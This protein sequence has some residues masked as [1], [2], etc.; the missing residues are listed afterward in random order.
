VLTWQKILAQGFSSAKELLQF[1]QLPLELYS[2]Q[3]EQSF[4]TRIPLSF[5][6]R[7]QAGNPQDPL[8]LQVLAS[9]WE[10]QQHSQYEK[11]PLQEKSSTRIPGLLHKYQGRV[12]LI[13]TG[14][15]AI[16]CR[17]CFRRHFPYQDNNPGREG[18][19]AAIDYIRAD[20]SIREVI[21][22]GGDPL[23][24]TE[25]LLTPLIEALDSIPHLQYL[26]FHS[27]IPVVL[28]ERINEALLAL[29]MRCSLKKIMVLH[30]NHPQEID[31]T[32]QEACYA[33]AESGC[34]LLN[35]SVLLQ[36]VNDDPTTLAQLSQRLFDCKVLP[37]YLHLLDKVAGTAHFDLPLEKALAIYRALQ[38]Q[39][40]GYLLPRLARE[41][42]G[43]NSK[44]LL[45]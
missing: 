42:P 20:S 25:A 30:C 18:W 1:L 11:D 21:L 37:Y 36:G 29:L 33:L 3:A 26:R 31:D 32:V 39:L 5:A 43:K 24:A 41:E 10:E 13:L 40:P 17:F 19:Q 44:T 8:L 12:L 15:C 14:S 27:R 23:L 38:A 2:K 28:P 22:S 16:N 9:P 35:Q 4:A 34:Q 7:M 45:I 6:K